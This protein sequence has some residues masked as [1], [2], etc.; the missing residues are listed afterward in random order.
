MQHISKSILIILSILLFSSCN[1]TGEE[2]G[3][4]PINEVSRDNENLI[5]KETTITLKKDENIGFWSEM[6]MSYEG[7]LGLRFRIEILKDDLPYGGL[8]IDPM[9]KNITLGEFKTDINGKVDWSFTGK[10]A[11]LT[12][13]EDADYTFK[14]VLLS[15]NNPTLKIEKAEVIIK[16]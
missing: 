5:M 7:D 16:K 2:V 14:G 9:E 15:N 4:L 6:D 8:E 12:I 10:N 3:R 13:D 11:S 1:I